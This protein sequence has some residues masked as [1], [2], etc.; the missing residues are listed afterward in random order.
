MPNGRQTRR[1]V[2]S[3]TYGSGYRTT[4]KVILIAIYGYGV[5]LTL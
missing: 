1:R 3:Q 4:V 5:L 2:A